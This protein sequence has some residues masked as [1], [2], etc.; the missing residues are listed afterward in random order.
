MVGSSRVH[1]LFI[2]GLVFRAMSFHQAADSSTAHVAAFDFDKTLT[3]R[4][5]VLPFLR[6]FTSGF[7]A[8]RLAFAV[9]ALSSAVVRG[10][11]D[12]IKETVTRRVLAGVNEE[13]I[14][15]VA[16]SLS[17]VIADNWLRPDMLDLLEQHK[18][19][20]H[21]TGI[22]SASFGAYVRPVGD[23]LGVDFVIASEIEIGADG[24][25]TGGLID[26]NCRGPEKARRLRAWLQDHDLGD[27]VLHAYGDSSGDREMLAM[28]DHPRLLKRK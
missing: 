27:A 3:S 11:R 8:F 16:A 12:S 9:P 23:L 1:S 15:R 13:D 6:S 24:N 25:A 14:E 21:R 4:D 26:G 2:V 17:R 20:G 28:A 18:A 7:R 19:L 10:D 22:V 5:C